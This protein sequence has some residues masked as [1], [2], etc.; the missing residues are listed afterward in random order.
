MSPRTFKKLPNLVTLMPKWRCVNCRYGKRLYWNWGSSACHGGLYK[1]MF[2]KKFA[3]QTVKQTLTGAGV[4][5]RLGNYYSFAGT[6][7]RGY[8]VYNSRWEDTLTKLLFVRK[9]TWFCL[10]KCQSK[11]AQNFLKTSNLLIRFSCC[12]F[13]QKKFCLQML[14]KIVACKWNLS[15]Q[16]VFLPAF[17]TA[18]GKPWWFLWH[19]LC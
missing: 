10:K 11:L 8:C 19:T 9:L 17:A 16:T 4:W 6:K 1:K 3:G 2:Q 13:Q 5:S 14:W 7:I 15:S 12:N 18:W